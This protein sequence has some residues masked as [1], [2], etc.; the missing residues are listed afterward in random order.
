MVLEHFVRTTPLVEKCGD[1][2]CFSRLFIVAKRD[3]G[4]PKDAPLTS[5]RVTMD[6]LVNNCLKPVASTLP[7]ATVAST[8]GHRSQTRPRHAQRC[9]PYV[10]QSYDGCSGEQL[11][12]A[13][14]EYAPT[15]YVFK[16]DALHAFWAIPLF[17]LQHNYNYPVY[18]ELY[19][20]QAF[21][22]I[23]IT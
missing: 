22:Y 19:S 18:Y 23:L 14:H 1:P 9:T 20:M 10:I 21:S 2:R 17:H 12:Q 16:L 3:P 5:Y 11:S 13:S 6:A 15:G 4:T 7:L 8:P